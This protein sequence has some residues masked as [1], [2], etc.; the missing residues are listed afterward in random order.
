MSKRMNS[1]EDA[2]GRR[3]RKQ[4]QITMGSACRFSLRGLQ[5]KYLNMLEFCG[6]LFKTTI[7]FNE[8]DK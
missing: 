6:S 1:V 2:L 4:R 5:H 3:E 8:W 7:M